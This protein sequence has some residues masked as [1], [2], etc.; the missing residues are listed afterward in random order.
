MQVLHLKC[1]S[2]VGGPP[3]WRKQH[4][5]ALEKKYIFLK[6]SKLNSMNSI[7]SKFYV[8]EK[9]ENIRREETN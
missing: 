4:D 9:Y 3:E 5:I 8:S 6:A 7:F 1:M 2:W